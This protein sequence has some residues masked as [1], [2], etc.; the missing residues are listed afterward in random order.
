M[1]SLPSERSS[2]FKGVSWRGRVRRLAFGVVANVARSHF[3]VVVR[4]VAVAVASSEVVLRCSLF[5]TV[6]FADTESF[7][8]VS[9]HEEVE[10]LSSVPASR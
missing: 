10:E 6:V 7:C 5:L 3:C 1:S 2:L 8:L 4:E 9:S